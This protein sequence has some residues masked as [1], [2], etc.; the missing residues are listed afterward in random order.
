MQKE[1]VALLKKKGTGKTMGKS[2]S[3]E[4]LNRL[5][6]LLLS[7]ECNTVTIATLVTA[8]LM[9]DPTDD[10]A[11][12]IRKLTQNYQEMLPEKCHFLLSPTRKADYPVLDALLQHKDLSET[13]VNDVMD[14][15]YTNENNELNAAYL[16]GLRLKRETLLENT[17]AT[18]AM[19]KRSQH[20]NTSVNTLI[21]IA[22]PYDGFSRNW[23]LSP[24]AAPVLAEI[25]L[26]TLLHGVNE[27]GPK[28]GLNVT[29]LISEAN[30]SETLSLNDARQQIE[31]P[32]I[33]WAFIN[34]NAFSPVSAALVGLRQAMVKR[35]I[36]ATIEKLMLPLRAKNTLLVTGYTHPPYRDMLIQLLKHLPYIPSALV[37]RGMEGATLLPLDRKAPYSLH[38]SDQ[39]EKQFIRPKDLGIDEH[40]LPTIDAPSAKENLEVGLSIL[41]NTPSVYRDQ[42][43]YYCACIAT[44]AGV[45][46]PVTKI[47]TALAS[48][49]ALSRWNKGQA[50][51]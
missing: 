15:L 31:K 22:D 4:D 38:P 10:E 3:P 50:H 36:L 46:N 40:T 51:A 2:L 14:T 16:E 21:D 12:F 24:F 35:P 41:H 45:S 43:V 23:V 28:Y 32:D 17:T 37:L 47:K 48:G 7:P 6:K 1:L 49:N 8:I 13:Q 34:Q 27:V 33:G 5:P 20:Q 19:Q 39:T 18:L 11:P 25:G 29:K 44:M 42:L 30:K 26:P 9:L